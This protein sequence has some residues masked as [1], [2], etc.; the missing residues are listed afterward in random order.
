MNQAADRMEKARLDMIA[1]MKSELPA[2]TKILIK[3]CK[4]QYEVIKPSDDNFT[5]LVK[6]EKTGK[7]YLTS[8]WSIVNKV[9]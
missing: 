6:N 2:G 5:V 7:E 4:T 3:D 1:A 9:G 8:V